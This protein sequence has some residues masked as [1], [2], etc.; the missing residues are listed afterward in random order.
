MHETLAKD[1]LLS[2]LAACYVEE[3]G[4]HDTLALQDLKTAVDKGEKVLLPVNFATVFNGG[5]GLEEEEIVGNGQFQ[6]RLVWQSGRG[7]TRRP[8]PDRLSYGQFY[9]ANARIFKLLNLSGQA[10]IEYL[11]YQRQLGILLQT[12][13]TSSM[14]L[15]DHLHRQF[16]FESGARWHVIENSLQNAVLKKKDEHKY[17]NNN[18]HQNQQT[19]RYDTKPTRSYN[20]DTDNRRTNPNES[21][22]ETVCWL[23]NLYKGC[24]FGDRCKYPHVCSVDGC[25]QAHPAY[26]HSD[27]NHDRPPRF[28]TD[29]ASSHISNS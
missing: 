3:G 7:N 19:R 14:F 27:F 17:V 4:L 9:E 5:I 25:R 20:V 21:T 18:Q 11:D 6:G 28:R 8:T 10:E 24:Y 13:T 26:K 23:Y 22:G 15:L 1:R 16:V 29:K 12:F 2:R